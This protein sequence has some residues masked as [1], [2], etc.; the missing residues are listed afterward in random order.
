[1]STWLRLFAPAVIVAL[2]LLVYLAYSERL[3][4]GGWVGVA[5]FI[6]IAVGVSLVGAALQRKVN[7]RA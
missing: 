6:A 1:M 7:R 3:G 5:V 2:G 4:V